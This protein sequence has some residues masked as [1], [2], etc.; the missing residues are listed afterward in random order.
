[1]KEWKID[2]KNK[3]NYKTCNFFFTKE[4][5][6]LIEFKSKEYKD[7]KIRYLLLTSTIVYKGYA[8][9]KNSV[10]SKL[11]LLIEDCLYKN[12]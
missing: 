3:S 12:R 5:D 4:Y 2:N 11:S 6:I 8:L 10:L 7:K 9:I 1:M